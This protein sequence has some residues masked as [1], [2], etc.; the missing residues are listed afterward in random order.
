MVDTNQAQDSV[1]IRGARGGRVQWVMVA[2]LIYLLICAVGL[3]G[4]G[5]KL[6]TGDQ[7]KELFPFATNPFAGLGVGTVATALIQ[8]S[9]TVTS[10]T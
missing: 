8:S 6:A 5:F 7:A 1:E 9:S 3:I 4:S 10:K 2:G